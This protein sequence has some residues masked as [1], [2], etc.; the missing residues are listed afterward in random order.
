MQAGLQA[1]FSE[2]AD[3]NWT[4]RA[5]AFNC[6][7]L[8]SDGAETHCCKVNEPKHKLANISVLGFFL[9]PLSLKYTT[10]FDV[11]N[12]TSPMSRI[13]SSSSPTL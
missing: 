7:E 4:V 2:C 8:S 13:L 11:S 5:Y 9:F 12:N 10:V 1:Y 3:K 6:L